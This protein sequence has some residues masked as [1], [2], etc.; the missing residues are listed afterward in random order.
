MSGKRVF[1]RILFILLVIV[2]G[3]I[4]FHYLRPPTFQTPSPSFTPNQT[5][6]SIL[7]P[8]CRNPLF[9]Y[10]FLRRNSYSPFRQACLQQGFFTF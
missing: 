2:L 7:P 3:Y 1:N 6:F 9:Y 10:S 5:T 4:S 8:L